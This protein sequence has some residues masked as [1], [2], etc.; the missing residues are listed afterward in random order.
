[1]IQCVSCG[2]ENHENSTYCIVCG[3]KV[4]PSQNPEDS[5]TIKCPH[6]SDENPDNS[7]FCGQ[8]GFALKTGVANQTTEA[9]AADQK[10]SGIGGWL[11]L[12]LIGLICTIPFSIYA[13]YYLGVIFVHAPEDLLPVLNYEILVNLAA[14]L[15]AIVLL[16]LFCT[17]KRILPRAIIIYYAAVCVLKVIDVAWASLLDFD[18]DLSTLIGSFAGLAIWIPYFV[19]SIRVKNT[20]VN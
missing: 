17:K 8:C 20:F 19:Y 18:I 9:S 6:C 3:S 2:S 12:P 11:I 16:V 10:L 7:V 14:I 1:M 4:F 13:V 5:S 15:S